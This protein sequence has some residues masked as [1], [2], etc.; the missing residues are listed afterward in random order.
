MISIQDYAQISDRDVRAAVIAGWRRDLGKAYRAA[1]VAPYNAAEAG[2]M[3]RRYYP[4]ATA[5]VFTLHE[6]GEGTSVTIEQVVGAGDRV[7][8]DDRKWLT[9]GYFEDQSDVGDPLGTAA[10]QLVKRGDGRDNLGR[11]T[12]DDE[13]DFGDWVERLAKGNA[14]FRPYDACQPD[15]GAVAFRYDL[16]F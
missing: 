9:D 14:L 2:V 6:D 10:L 12:G 7:L 13:E 11:D 3:L 8:Y 1:R 15:S 5:V 16:P 4:E